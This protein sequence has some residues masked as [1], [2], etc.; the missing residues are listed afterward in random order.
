MDTQCVLRKESSRKHQQPCSV[1]TL[2]CFGPNLIV[3]LVWNGPFFQLSNKAGSFPQGICLQR[4]LPCIQ[5]YS[6]IS[7]LSSCPLEF[8]LLFTKQLKLNTLS[9]SS[10]GNLE[11]QHCTDKN[12]PE[13]ASTVVGHSGL[14]ISPFLVRFR[15]WKTIPVHAVRL[16]VSYA[17][18]SCIFLPISGKTRRAKDNRT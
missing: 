17:F 18:V 7:Y 2:C 1:S 16:A 11:L 5:R 12:T 15:F 6:Q 13:T 10:S 14:I 8:L 3:A 4:G 9:P